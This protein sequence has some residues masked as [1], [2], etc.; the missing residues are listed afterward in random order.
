[1]MKP[2]TEA[3]IRRS[4]DRS[5]ARRPLRLE[6]GR[7]RAHTRAGAEKFIT[8]VRFGDAAALFVPWSAERRGGGESVL[9]PEPRQPVEPVLA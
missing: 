1:M 9:G 7:R 6:I 4:R 3:H 2:V 5:A 8:E